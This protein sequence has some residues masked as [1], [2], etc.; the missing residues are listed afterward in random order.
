[1]NIF[2]ID[3]ELVLKPGVSATIA[4]EQHVHLV[5]VLKSSVG[6]V[7]KVG[8]VNKGVWSAH[9]KHIDL[10]LGQTHIELKEQVTCLSKPIHSIAIALPRPKAI[11]RIV[12]HIS[13]LGVRQITFFNA[14]RVEKSY[15]QST[16]AEVDNLLA[17]A[18]DGLRQGGHPWRPKIRLV[19]FFNDF[20]KEPNELKMV[21]TPSVKEPLLTELDLKDF[22]PREFI[23]GPEG[24]FIEKELDGFRR[25]DV[26]L[27]ALNLPILKTETAA[28]AVLAMA[29][30][31]K[32]METHQK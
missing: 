22:Q 24:G 14:W 13:T 29:N 10:G 23:L 32:Y 21:L 20:L 19:R 6:D 16:K 2:L 12:E 4:G 1:M 28:A 27:F 31:Y 17:Y 25:L 11:K 3:D 5:G 8:F 18:D 26:P 7:V 9:V 30:M 15:W